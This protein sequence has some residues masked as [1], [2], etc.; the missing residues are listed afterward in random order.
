MMGPAVEGSGIRLEE[1]LVERKLGSGH[2]WVCD[3]GFWWLR[4]LGLGT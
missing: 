3:D 1:V 2:G 4:L